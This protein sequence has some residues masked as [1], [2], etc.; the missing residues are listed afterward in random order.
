VCVL[1]SVQET[2]CVLTPVQTVTH[3]R[4][5]HSTTPRICGPLCQCQ[6]L[7]VFHDLLT[8]APAKANFLPRSGRYL[9]SVVILSCDMERYQSGDEQ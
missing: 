5:I 6:D 2:A 8:A 3:T 4:R 1:F 7:Y 9:R